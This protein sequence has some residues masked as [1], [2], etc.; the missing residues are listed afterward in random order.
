MTRLYVSSTSA[1]YVPATVRGGWE[2]TTG[3]ITKA[4]Y[5]AQDVAGTTSIQSVM[6]TESTSTTDYDVLLLRAISPPL[7]ADHTFAGTLNAMFAVAESLDDANFSYYLHAFITQGNSDTLRGTLLA[8]YADPQTNEWP[9]S[10]PAGKALSAAQALSSVAAIAGDRIIVEI[11]FRARNTITGSRNGRIYYG[12]NGN[13]M[14]AGGAATSGIGYL[15]FSDTFT[16]VDNPALRATQIAVEAVRRPANPIMRV[17]QLSTEVLRKPDSARLRMSQLT[18]EVVRKNGMP[19][20]V[21]QQPVV[22]IVT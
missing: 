1:G 12:G 9:V 11:G 14:V 15:D 13:D 21:T 5:T 19:A 10:T 3:H 20:A 22:I 17:T 18:I 4:M 2:Y 16:L 8:N 6:Q 7:A